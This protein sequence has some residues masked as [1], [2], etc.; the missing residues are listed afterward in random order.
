MACSAQFAAARALPE[1]LLGEL[2]EATGQYMY[3]KHLPPQLEC[4]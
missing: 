3:G 2:S 4:P 1:A